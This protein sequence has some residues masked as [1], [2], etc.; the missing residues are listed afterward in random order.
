MFRLLYTRGK[1][2]NTA[3]I[4][5][6]PEEVEGAPY[7]IKYFGKEENFLPSAAPNTNPVFSI[8]YIVYSIS[9]ALIIVTAI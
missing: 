2:K 1:E 3:A 6:W 8:P 4:S 9:S 7:S 5:L